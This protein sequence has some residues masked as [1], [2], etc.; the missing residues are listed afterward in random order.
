[1]VSGEDENGGEEDSAEKRRE[2]HLERE[3][4]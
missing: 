3:E 4:I 2:R 1:L